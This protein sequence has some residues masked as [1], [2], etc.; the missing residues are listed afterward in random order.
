MLE[1]RDEGVLLSVRGHGEAAAII[2]VFTAFH[3]L[4]AGVVPG[5]GSRKAAPLLQPGAQLQLVW[6]ARLDE[7]IGSFVAEPVRSRAGILDDHLGLMGLNAVRALLRLALPEREPHPELYARTVPLLDAFA[8]GGGRGEKPGGDWA[9]DYLAW[10]RLLLEQTG[11]GLDL[12]SCAVTG[13][14]DGLAFVSPRTGRAVSRGAA[15]EWADRLLPLPDCLADPAGDPAG[16]AAGLATTGYFLE[17]RL[18]A[19][20]GAGRLPEARRRLVAALT[21]G[22]V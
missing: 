13:A 17:H 16:L 18:A 21:G 4:H 22:R 9:R 12:A 6:R 7:H 10:E 2:E 14:T 5:G 1:W 15:G 8:A 11:Y 20:R 19:E 3:G